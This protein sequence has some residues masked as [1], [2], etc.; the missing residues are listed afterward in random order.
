MNWKDFWTAV[1]E[2]TKNRIVELKNELKDTSNRSQT[3]N[4]LAL[5][6]INENWQTHA[7]S[8]LVKLW[9]VNELEKR[10]KVL[11]IE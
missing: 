3:R 8:E 10:R 7:R 5:V 9:K 2:Q 6:K 4:R 1:L 11:S